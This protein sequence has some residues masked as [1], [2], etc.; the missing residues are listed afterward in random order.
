[1]KISSRLYNARK[2]RS[3]KANGSKLIHR[4][5]F[6]SNYEPDPAMASRKQHQK[7]YYRLEFKVQ[8]YEY[9]FE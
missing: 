2:A 1:M 5:R 9:A 6:T 7:R 4:V 8:T 3:S